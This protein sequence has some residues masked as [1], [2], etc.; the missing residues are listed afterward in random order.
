VAQLEGAL[1]SRSRH[2]RARACW[3]SSTSNLGG[4]DLAALEQIEAVCAW[5]TRTA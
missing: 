4:G 1:Q 5:H 3:R 2:A